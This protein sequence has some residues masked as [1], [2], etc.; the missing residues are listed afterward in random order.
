[1]KTN[2]TLLALLFFVSPALLLGQEQKPIVPDGTEGIF[3]VDPGM[4]STTGQI[5]P[6]PPNEFQNGY[7]TFKVGL[8]FIHDVITYSYDDV[9]G[10]QLDSL[11][12]QLITRGK[13]RD[14]RILASGKL[15]T[16]RT[17]SWK[18]AF[19]WDGNLDT[20]LVRESGIIIGVPELAGH[21]FIGR[22]KE[23]YSMVK[24]MNGHS[25]WT[26]ERQM[27]IDLIPIIADGIKWYGSL[28]KSRIFWNLGA[29]NDFV[30]EG[31]GFSTYSSQYSG[32]I[33]W[34]P[35]YDAQK[36]KVLHIAANLR[37]GK[38]LDRKFRARSRP[39]SNPTPY[40]ID[41]GTFP[42]DYSTHIGAEIYYSTGR[43][44]VGS[45]VA[46][47]SFVSKSSENHLFT[48]GDVVV[49]YLFTKTKRPYTTTGSLFGFV[50]AGESIFN[51]GIGAIEGVLHV[52]SFD[53]TDGN[54]QGGKMWRITPMVNWYMSKVIR[55]ELVYGYG[56][57]D[58]YG[59][60]GGVH[61]YQGRIQFTIM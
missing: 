59:L 41:T 37:Y 55:L 49:S 12:Q 29:Y 2:V 22:T 27:A 47:H 16:K 45:E 3:H 33:G 20:W 26:A 35:V 6:L 32:R 30:S 28:P 5:N 21:I 4:D 43:F 24:V 25:P 1:M 8:G 10:Q 39:E 52:S 40:L 61:F 34:L 53:L 44:M 50:P 17:L 58:R 14:F 57:L 31:Q 7:S 60:K 23:G 42:A 19:M 51:G 38:P 54:I 18:F 11:N 15:N 56:Q 9:F 13:L 48:G 36:Q 46:S